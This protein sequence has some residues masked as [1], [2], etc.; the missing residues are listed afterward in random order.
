MVLLVKNVKTLLY[1]L[2]VCII[3]I[4]A[5]YP[6]LWLVASSL[7]PNDEIYRTTSLIPSRIE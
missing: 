7:K 2:I 4:T 1:H 5:I 3:A 6:I